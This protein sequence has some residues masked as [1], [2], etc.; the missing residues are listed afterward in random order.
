M[1]GI[2]AA[3]RDARGIR[4]VA[5]DA[6]LYGVNALAAPT[7]EDASGDWKLAIKSRLVP[8]DTLTLHSWEIVVYGH[9]E[10]STTTGAPDALNSVREPACGRFAPPEP[11]G[12][13]PPPPPGPPRASFPVDGA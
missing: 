6:K 4:G 3:K 1:A 12:P 13:T 2:A 9:G 11:P 5:P 10:S 7:D 8:G